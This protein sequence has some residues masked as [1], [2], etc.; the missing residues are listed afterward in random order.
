MTNGCRNE[1]AARGERYC[2]A[3]GRDALVPRYTVFIHRRAERELLSLPKHVIERFR[4][5]FE[6][7]EEDPYRPRPGCDIRLIRG[8][9]HVR[10]VRVGSYRGIYEVLEDE[11]AV[12]FTKFGARGSVYG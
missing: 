9:P 11:K 8:H 7:L 6:M 5:V 4:K 3:G 12:W 1:R 10:A 2:A